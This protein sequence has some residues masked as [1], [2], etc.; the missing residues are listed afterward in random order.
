MLEIVLGAA[1]ILFN[2]VFFL[3]I[4]SAMYTLFTGNP[5]FMYPSQKRVVEFCKEFAEEHGLKHMKHIFME[6]PYKGYGLWIKYVPPGVQ[7][8]YSLLFA[9][10]KCNKPL[11]GSLVIYSHSYFLYIG[12][13]KVI[14]LGDQEFD[15]VFCVRIN[16]LTLSEVNTILTPDVKRAMLA[17]TGINRFAIYARKKSIYFQTRGF[18]NDKNYLNDTIEMMFN[19]LK[20]YREIR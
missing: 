1:G 20:N 5:L 9:D 11:K 15:R 12:K 3:A 8:T 13:S 17:L 6:G 7:K 18:D 16:N 2:F 10:L 19:M 4:V 14:V